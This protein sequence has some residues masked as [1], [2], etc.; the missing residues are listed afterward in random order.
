L[1][2]ATAPIALLLFIHGFSEHVDRY[3]HVFALF[4]E[5][6]I[7]TFAWDQRG[8][9]KSA[10]K[11]EDWGRT[12]GTEKALQDVDFFVK[13]TKEEAQQS[14]IPLFLWGHSMVK[15]PLLWG[16][17]TNWVREGRWR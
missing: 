16:T 7:K 4:A 5:R 13:K 6:G 10:L 12:G 1:K 14:N 17:G 9:G 8:F 11:K 15:R 3:D 2:P